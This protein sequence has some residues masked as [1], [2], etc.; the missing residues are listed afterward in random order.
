MNSRAILEI[1]AL[2]L[3]FLKEKLHSATPRAITHPSKK[4][5]SC[6]Y[7][8]N[9]TRIH[10]ITI[11]NYIPLDGDCERLQLDETFLIASV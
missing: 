1:I 8:P 6:N 10:A 9:C 5:G 11:T 2:A 4:R 3:P 7:F